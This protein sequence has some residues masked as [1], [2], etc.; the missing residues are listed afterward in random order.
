MIIP[1]DAYAQVVRVGGSTG[2]GVDDI[3]FS[4]ITASVRTGPAE[5]VLG[6]GGD[7]LIPFDVEPTPEEQARIIRRLCT[8]NDNEA[9]LQDRADAALSTLRTIAG[10]TGAIPE[11]QLSNAIRFLA[12]TQIGIIRLVLHRLEDTE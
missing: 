9:T 7:V 12:R 6:S 5:T 10:S 1:S 3:D 8:T 2:L 4:D 11:P